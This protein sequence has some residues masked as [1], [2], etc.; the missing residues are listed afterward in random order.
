MDYYI[1]TITITVVYTFMD[2]H[3]FNPNLHFFGI[4]FHGEAHARYTPFSRQYTTVDHFPTFFLFFIF[5]FFFFFLSIS[6]IFC[7]HTLSSPRVESGVNPWVR[8][9]NK[10]QRKKKIQEPK[11]NRLSLSSYTINQPTNLQPPQERRK[12]RGGK[13]EGPP[14]K[15][16]PETKGPYY[17]NVLGSFPSE[18]LAP[19]WW[20]EGRSSA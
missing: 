11:A 20:G 2:G 5:L 16:E 12:Q 1:I 14:P 4:S 8:P 10:R 3:F 13:K 6:L 18:S 19:A 15:K 17:P 9:S 7:I